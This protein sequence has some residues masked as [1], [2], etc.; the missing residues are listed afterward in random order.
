MTTPPTT[1]L[2]ICTV[3]GMGADNIK[4][5]SSKFTI[6]PTRFRD[7]EPD[8]N[9][10]DKQWSKASMLDGIHGRRDI[11]SQ[12]AADDSHV[13]QSEHSLLETERPRREL[14][15]CKDIWGKCQDHSRHM[16]SQI[17]GECNGEPLASR[18]QCPGAFRC[19][20]KD[21]ENLC[22]YTYYSHLPTLVKVT[23]VNYPV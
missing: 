10:T 17:V 14:E 8:P 22:R 11:Q 18:S 4:T 21:G 6:T 23:L 3:F 16:E 19:S 9:D 13:L 1:L 12:I 15:A 2:S 5:F 20:H 7:D